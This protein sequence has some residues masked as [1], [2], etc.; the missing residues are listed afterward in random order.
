MYNVNVFFHDGK[1]IDHIEA[2]DY[3]VDEHLLTVT[4]EGAY[5][6]YPMRSLK[7]FKATWIEADDEVKH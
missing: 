3:E 5:Y 2:E 6:Y 1:S 7:W 4:V